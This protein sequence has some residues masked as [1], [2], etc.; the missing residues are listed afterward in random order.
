MSIYFVNL[1]L[2][3]C[4]R[5]GACM[6]HALS[7][8][9]SFLSGAHMNATGLRKEIVNFIKTHPSLEING[10]SLTQWIK[11]DAGSNMDVYCDNMSK[12]TTYGGGIELI[13]IFLFLF[14]LFV[15]PILICNFFQ[16]AAFVEM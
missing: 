14:C 5:D 6:F 16:C 12:S 8:W 7:F 10:I 3:Y 13:G 1:K 4:K 15:V 2:V 9:L 11:F